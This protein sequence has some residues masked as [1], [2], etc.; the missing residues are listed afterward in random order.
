ML[1]I[2]VD[3]PAGVFGKEE[4]QALGRR[5][6]DVL[7]TEDGSHHPDVLNAE[8]NLMHA[9]VRENED[10]VLGQRPDADPADPPRYLVRVSAPASWRKEMSATVIEVLTDALAQFEAEAGRDPERLREHPHALIHV[11]GVSENGI[12]LYGR[13]MGGRALEDHVTRPFRD[14]VLEGRIEEPGPGK[15]LDPVC[16]MVVD[17]DAATLTLQYDGK[18]YGFCS[19]SCRRSFADEYGV[20]LGG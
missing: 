12:G 5:L 14:A 19:R 10:W 3:V 2:E 8:R 15:L 4:R 18:I 20:T 1:L 9:I 17:E 7:M 16:G 13:S 6:I 11:L